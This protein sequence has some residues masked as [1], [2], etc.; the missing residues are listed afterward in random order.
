MFE[1]G[2]AIM[3][4]LFFISDFLLYIILIIEQNLIR[5]PNTVD[6]YPHTVIKRSPSGSTIPDCY[7]HIESE[8]D[9]DPQ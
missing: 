2:L 5:G 6:C 4:V 7:P 8:V 1:E 9:Q 3:W